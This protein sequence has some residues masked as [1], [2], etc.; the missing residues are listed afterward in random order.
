MEFVYIVEIKNGNTYEHKQF[1]S[2]RLAR[3][4]YMEEEHAYLYKLHMKSGLLQFVD[5]K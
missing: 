3:K 2:M 4:K 1:K 5:G